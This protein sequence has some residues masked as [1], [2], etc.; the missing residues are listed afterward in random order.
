VKKIWISKWIARF[1]GQIFF[2]LLVLNELNV[3][4]VIGLIGLWKFHKTNQN[5][6]IGLLFA[7]TIG[8]CVSVNIFISKH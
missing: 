2:S 1:N 7:S 4:C 8:Y 5:G 6:R 3:K